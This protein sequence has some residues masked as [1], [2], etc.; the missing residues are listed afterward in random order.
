MKQLLVEYLQEPTKEKF[1]ALREAVRT[2][3]SYSPYS[4]DLGDIEKALFSNDKVKAGELLKSAFPNL[5]LSPRA[6]LFAAILA[7]GRDDQNT[8]QMETYFANACAQGILFTGDGSEASPYLVL[9]VEDEY[10]ILKFLEK[11][12]KSQSLVHLNGRRLDRV[13]LED[14]STLWFDISDAYNTLKFS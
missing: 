7:R 6:H 3:A 12:M 4:T 11:K 2:H 5:L 9:R 10:D 13:V 8:L 1:L 14:D